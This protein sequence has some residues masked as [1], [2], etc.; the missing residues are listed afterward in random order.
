MST[1]K[2]REKKTKDDGPKVI[3]EPREKELKESFKVWVNELYSNL[4]N[5]EE[6]KTSYD[7]FKFVG[8][9]RE[10]VLEQIFTVFKETHIVSEVVLA[11]A[12]RGPV[13][14]HQL[15]L[16]NGK[17]IASYGVNANG[18]RRN[19]LLTCNKIQASTA[20]LAAFYLKKLNISKRISSLPCPSWLQFPSAGSLPLDDILRKQH[21]EFAIAFSK[22]ITQGPNVVGNAVQG[23][24]QSIYDQM[25]SNTYCDDRLRPFLFG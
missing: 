8:F 16:S 4:L 14:A 3:I 20:D 9:N 23:F 24:N 19:K 12:L 22:L 7:A 18:G 21:L 6:L 2:K 5:E 13:A 10:E 17:T 1:E 25:S 15:R 11:I